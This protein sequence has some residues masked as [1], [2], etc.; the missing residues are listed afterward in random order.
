[1]GTVADNNEAMRCSYIESILH[2]SIRI[3]THLTEKGLILIP[4]L[5]VSGGKSHGRVDYA[6]KKILDTMVEESYA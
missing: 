1:M 2:A 3:V 5:E 6:V 4:Q